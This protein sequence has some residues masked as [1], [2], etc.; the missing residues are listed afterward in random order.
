M[1]DGVGGVAVD[2]AGSILAAG[3]EQQKGQTVT[4][5][6]VVRKFRESGSVSVAVPTPDVIVYP[7][8]VKGDQFVVEFTD[9]NE[10]IAELDLQLFN[11]AFDRVYRAGWR[12]VSRVEPSVRVD[13]ALKWAPGVYL[14]RVKGTL[15]GG[16]GI[17]FPVKKVVVRR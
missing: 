11:V 8:P 3:Y 13:G 15:A 7:N 14:L 16:G 17:R 12:D 1:D 4:A 9:L 6:W 5:N 10:D 2:G